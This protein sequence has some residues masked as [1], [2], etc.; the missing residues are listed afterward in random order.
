[1]REITSA[2]FDSKDI[3]LN[4]GD[5]ILVYRDSGE[6]DNKFLLSDIYILDRVKWDNEEWLM[7]MN[8]GDYINSNFD[9]VNNK[10]SIIGVDKVFILGNLNDMVEI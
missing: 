9:L 2:I 7:I 4:E 6:D 8:G 1:M 3:N 5:V 10:G